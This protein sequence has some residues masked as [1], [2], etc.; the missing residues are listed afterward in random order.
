MLRQVSRLVVRSL[1]N[2]HRVDR[3]PKTFDRSVKLK[4]FSFRTYSG[5]SIRVD[6][7]EP[8]NVIDRL[9]S[10]GLISAMTRYEFEKRRLKKSV[11]F[12]TI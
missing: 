12:A 8:K 10:R 5:P 11:F 3:R 9:V 2:E 7:S 4:N 1:N 6:D